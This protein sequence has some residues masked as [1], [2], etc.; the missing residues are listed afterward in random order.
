MIEPKQDFTHY[1][2]SR[3]PINGK[4]YLNSKLKVIDYYNQ[5]TYIVQFE[6]GTKANIRT[7]NIRRLK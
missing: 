5:A 4:C 2:N 1:Y 3:K 6:D 7:M